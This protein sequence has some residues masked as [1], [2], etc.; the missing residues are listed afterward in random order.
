MATSR[1]SATAGPAD[2]RAMNDVWQRTLGQI[3][4]A[5]G[6]LVYLASLRNANTGCYQHFGLAQ[7]YGADEADRVLRS[8]HES[9]FGEWLNFDLASQKS[10]LDAY[11]LSV[12][13]DRTT[14]LDAWES[15]SPY[16]T[17]TPAAAGDAER[18]LYA[19][20][21]EIILEILRNELAS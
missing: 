13:D 2:G 21:L 18:F 10:D 20:D 17:L 6:K 7:L 1:S 19:S 12:G 14:V 3:P 9:V 16:K 11:L 4:T 15:L 8:S 5:F